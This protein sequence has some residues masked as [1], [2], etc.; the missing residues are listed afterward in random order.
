MASIEKKYNP[1]KITVIIPIFNEVLCIEKCLLQPALRDFDQVIIVD[2]CSDDGSREKLQELPSF[3]LL[4]S[5]SANRAIQMNLGAAAS[6]SDLL[7]FLHADTQL[8]INAAH[9]LR[10]K[11]LA[12]IDCG[13]FRRKFT[14]TSTLLRFTSYLAYW[15]SR[16]SFWSYGDQALFFSRSL[17]DSLT[18]YKELS[19]FEDLDICQRAKRIGK[20]SVIDTPIQTSA[21]RFANA[22]LKVL[23]KDLALS[24]GFLLGL[25]HPK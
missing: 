10:R 17:F 12:G 13:C 4:S 6:D 9:L 3:T 24:L 25:Y 16:L 14:H 20:Y 8:P 22:P 15:R 2:G 5:K 7:L 19:S 11:F 21:R 18:G 1:P 23:L